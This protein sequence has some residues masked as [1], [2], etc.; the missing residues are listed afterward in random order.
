MPKSKRSFF[1]RLTGA[2]KVDDDEEE[3]EERVEEGAMPKEKENWIEEEVGDAQLTAD[4]Y[5]TSNDV[6]IK[7]MVAG[8]KPDCGK[9]I[10]TPIAIAFDKFSTICFKK[11]FGKF[12]P[13]L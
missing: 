3:F 2:V 9:A 4:V 1:E 5:Q 6:I 11:S 13:Y 7:T 10:K 12:K 8:V